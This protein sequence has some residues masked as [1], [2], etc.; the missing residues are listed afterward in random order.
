MKRD[1]LLTLRVVIVFPGA[2]AEGVLA[3]LLP[4]SITQAA[5]GTPWL[6]LLSTLLVVAAI[7]G[8][9]M[10]SPVS[11]WLGSRQMTVC[12][13]AISTM[14]LVCAILTW[15]LD[16]KLTTFLLALCAIAADGIADLGFSSRTPVIAR[17]Y[18]LSLAKF[19]GG[20]WLWAILGLALG[21]LTA[22]WC[23]SSN[24][25]G[26]L[27]IV[28]SANSLLVAISV[29]KFLPRDSRI[30]KKDDSAMTMLLSSEFW[31]P[32]MIALTICVGWLTF[33]YGP[34]DNL[35]IA[36]QLAYNDK[37]ASLFGELVT[38]GGVGLAVGLAAT[39]ARQTCLNA[40]KTFI[41]WVGIFAA[42]LQIILVWQLP[43]NWQLILG[44]FITAV[45]FAPFL[46]MLESTLLLSVKTPYRTLVLTMVGTLTSVADML[47]TATAG[48]GIGY[49]GIN[50]V[51]LMC[52]L[53]LSPLLAYI[54]FVRH[55]FKKIV[56]PAND[57]IT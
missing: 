14:C 7:V 21:S 34:M 25:I 41:L 49:V 32:Q 12:A 19:S 10:A 26:I 35:L 20:N 13:A 38:A 31:T 15:H 24:L 5:I 36:A 17:L 56:L 2:F 43:E 45:M 4:W 50:T 28:L 46:P 11:H 29:S 9:V 44:T 53:A 51:L 40:S 16:F 23:M 8:S 37:D 52:A 33:V 55:V 27:L 47:G 18:K 42:I 22:G 6:G 1:S 39:Q 48:L 57:L 54:Y 3:V 30:S